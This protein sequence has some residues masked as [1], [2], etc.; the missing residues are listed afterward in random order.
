M[1]KIIS[2]CCL[3]CVFISC[4]TKPSLDIAKASLKK[5][6]GYSIEIVDFTFINGIKSEDKKIGYYNMYFDATIKFINDWK[7]D[8]PGFRGKTYKKGDTYKID[9]GII[10]FISTDNGWIATQLKLKIPNGFTQL[11]ENIEEKIPVIT[12]PKDTQSK[13]KSDDKEE[14][15][16]FFWESFKEEVYAKDIKQI[17]NLTSKDFFD[18]GGGYTIQE[19]LNQ[20][21]FTNNDNFIEF[22]KTLQGGVKD[23]KKQ[24]GSLYKATGKSESGDLYFEFENGKWVF[25]GVVG[26]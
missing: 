16:G 12:K 21:V 7:D 13:I 17:A 24:D 20:V 6:Y 15:W 14:K 8:S 4:S 2:L 23:F 26:D 18:G 5:N 10:D 19:W 3:C 1:K 9:Y 22:K 11:Y 25:G